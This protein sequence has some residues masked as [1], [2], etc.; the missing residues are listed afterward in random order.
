MRYQLLTVIDPVLVCWLVVNSSQ[1]GWPERQDTREM[2]V[3]WENDCGINVSFKRY[4]VWNRFMKTFPK[5]N[6][7]FL[8]S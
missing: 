7:L 2:R 6:S 8:E 4:L 1:F 5:K 3:S